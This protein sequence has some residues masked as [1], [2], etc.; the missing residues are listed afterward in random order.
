MGNAV[1]NEGLI[2]NTE[3]GGLP[4][5]GWYA[6]G[7]NI[8][9]SPFGGRNFEYYSEDPYLSGIMTANVMKG[10]AEKGVYC[11]LKHFALNEQET[12]RSS[13]GVLTWAT[14]Q[15]MREVYLKA[16]EI[17]I[18]ECNRQDV[19]ITGV[20]SSFNRID[21]DWTGGDYRLITTILRDEWGFEGVVICD[22][23]T[24]SH[25]VEKDM[26]YAD[27][28]LNLQ[29]ANLELWA[30]DASN[31]SDVTVLR[32]ASKN[33]L[34]VVAN[35]N[36]MRGDFV[37]VMPVWQIVMIVVDVVI[38]LGLGIWGFFVVRKALKKG[39]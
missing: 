27:G 13:N 2:G 35:S 34:Y 39:E 3:N 10:A 20:M 17:A 16:F 12:H 28:D 6:P 18:K 25:I 21:T 7:L 9:R 30:P 26:F 4:Y 24:C 37:V 38:V 33:I 29:V 15:S 23:N 11:E 36:A 31:P 8:H 19:K 32:Q 1:G 5:S 22:F 14:E